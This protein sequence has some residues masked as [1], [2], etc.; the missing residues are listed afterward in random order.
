MLASGKA[1]RCQHPGAGA[2][3]RMSD[4]M[5]RGKATRTSMSYRLRACEAKDPHGDRALVLVSSEPG[6]R[7]VGW[8]T[9]MLSGH[10]DEGPTGAASTFPVRRSVLHSTMFSWDR[11]FFRCPEATRRTLRKPRQPR[12]RIAGSGTTPSA[13]SSITFL[14]QE[15]QDF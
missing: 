15:S 7:S 1:D 5:A 9:R 14:R 8:P 3:R 2:E 6:A 11:W 10:A 4:S 12:S 13:V